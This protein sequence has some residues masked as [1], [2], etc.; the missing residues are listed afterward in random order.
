NMWSV[1]EG[2]S[3]A[4]NIGY[5]DR[6]TGNKKPLY[7]HFKMMADN[8]RG[9]YVNGTTNQTT[10]KSFGSQNSLQTVVLILNEDLSSNYNCKVR[11][12][13][14]AIAGTS[15]LKININANIANEYTQVIPSQSS[16]LLIFNS[17]GALIKKYEYSL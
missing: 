9:N 3:T 4:L 7:Y 13:T 16:V 11:L 8:F 2:N 6:T 5:L 1:I 14:A 12:N 17:A 10:V 15:N